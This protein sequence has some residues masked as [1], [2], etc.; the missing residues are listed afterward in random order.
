[1]PNSSNNSSKPSKSVGARSFIGLQNRENILFRRHLSENRGFLRQVS[2]PKRARRYIGKLVTSDYLGKFSFFGAFQAR[3]HIKRR[4][5]PAPFAPR[6]R[7][8]RLA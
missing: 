6:V 1:M 3:H 5:F 7:R 8:R 2:K 4:R